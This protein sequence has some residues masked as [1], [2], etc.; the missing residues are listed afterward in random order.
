MKSFAVIADCHLPDCEDS[1]QEA[2]LTW[3]LD[4]CVQRDVEVIAAAGDVTAAGDLRTVARFQKLLKST[5]IPIV[6]TPGNAELR[7]AQEAERARAKLSEPTSFQG[8]EWSMLAVDTADGGV[9]DEEKARLEQRL[10]EHP[11]DVVLLTHWP[12]QELV[13]EDSAWVESLCTSEK[14]GLIVAG[15]KHFDGVSRLGGVPVHLVRGLDPDKAKHGPPA[16]ALFEREPSGA[17][18]RDDIAWPQA[19]P[20]TWAETNRKE[21]AAL[22][23]VSTMSRTLPYLKEA[24]AA[25][26]P[27]VELRA[28][29]AL[30]TDQGVLKAR[31]AQWRA[32]GGATLSLHAPNLRWKGGTV[33]GIEEFAEF[34]ELAMRLGA[35]RV[36]VHVPRASL[37]EMTP[38][39]IAWTA[40]TKVYADSLRPLVSDGLVIGVENLHMNHGE[41]CDEGRGFGYLPDEC[42][43]WIRQLRE[44]LPG[45]RVG[46]HLD[47]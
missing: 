35:D 14:L 9:W 12:P 32:S 1:A 45:A 25:G 46:M 11:G 7:T 31:V 33:A 5:S 3:A 21:F 23:G 15:H 40:F 22:L 44:A 19:D 27:C 2:A 36:T 10:A 28:K 26:I 29:E 34:A 38:G 43:A 6:S 39:G 18:R 41:P 4:V 8:T 20:R 24:T 13:T 37:G 47:L 42:L 16:V 30:T 17:W